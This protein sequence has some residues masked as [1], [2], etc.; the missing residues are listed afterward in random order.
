YG[1]DKLIR[2]AGRTLRGFLFVINQVHDSNRFTFSQ[3]R[4]PSFHVTEED[5]EGVQLFT[6]NVLFF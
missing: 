3:M 2:I 6:S 1:F 5:D 4:Y